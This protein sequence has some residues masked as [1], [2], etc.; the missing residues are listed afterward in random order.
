MLLKVYEAKKKRSKKRN[1]LLLLCAEISLCLLNCNL[2]LKPKIFPSPK[3][4]L[5]LKIPWKY[6]FPTIMFY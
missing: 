5:H 4:S 1:N 2:K 3:S 6:D